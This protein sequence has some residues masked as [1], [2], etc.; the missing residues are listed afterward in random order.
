MATNIMKLPS[1]PKPILVGHAPAPS[2]PAR[3][4]SGFV[5]PRDTFEAA[6]STRSTPADG[7]GGSVDAHLNY[8]GG[9]ILTRPDVVPVYLGNYW[10][11]KQGWKDVAHNDKA[12]KNMVQDPG[13]NSVWAQYGVGSGAFGGHL[14]VK[15]AYK[16]G[17]PITDKQI[18]AML[19]DQ[20]ASGAANPTVSHTVADGETLSSIAASLSKQGIVGKRLNLVIAH[21]EQLNP[22]VGPDQALTAGTTIK[23]PGQRDPQAIYTVVLPPGAVLTMDDGTSSLQGLGGYHGNITDAQGKPVYYAAIAYSK[24]DN[25]I[26]FTHGKAM[27]NISITE[28]HEITEAA[29][30]PDV[31]AAIAQNSFAP[32]GWYDPQNGEIGDI[33]VN[34][35]GLPLDKTF[36]YVNGYAYQ[37]EWSNEDKQNEVKAKH[38]GPVQPLPTPTPAAGKFSAE[39]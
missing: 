11:T 5:V 31:D 36:S 18:R 3:L 15:G 33:A 20:V 27:D 28:S 19:H 39:A 34:D 14:R 22:G 38:P 24:G 17:Q 4:Q 9:K 8:Y 7:G 12:M 37:K 26:D 32:L 13:Y 2:A 29:T 16:P 10:G 30:D 25:G 35:G 1:I 6:P 21:L 23:V